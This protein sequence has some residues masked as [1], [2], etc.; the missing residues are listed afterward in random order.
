MKNEKY[1]IPA[2]I[3][4]WISEQDPEDQEIYRKLWLE[5]GELP[6]SAPDVSEDELNEAYAA[7]SSILFEDSNQN[8][9]E[10]R[11]TNSEL[12]GRS[13]LYYWAAAA[14]LTIA[15]SLGYMLYITGSIDVNA[16]YGEQVS[17]VF[18]DGSSVDL[19]SGSSISF[20]RSFSSSVRH[21]TLNGEAFFEIGEDSRPFIVETHNAMVK[22]MGTSFNV[23]SRQD[24]AEDETSVVISDG[25]VEFYPRARPDNSVLLK[26]GQLSRL[27]EL[28]ERP[29]E[30]EEATV[31]RFLAWRQGGLFFNDQPLELIFSEI[32]RRFDARIEANPEA[33]QNQRFSVL[34]SRPESAE[35]VLRDICEENM[36]T[37]NVIGEN[38]FEIY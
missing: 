9:P 2:D 37:M 4:R 25:E 32:E 36:L 8:K 6:A 15:A 19:N 12:T 24:Q 7:V 18:T 1:F 30:P 20:R 17:Y 35:R 23:R 31:E 28:S 26:P 13:Q 29:T 34:Y 21:V 14:V 27:K 3:E 16:A 10:Y 11:G 5:T 38:Q 33:I 22:V